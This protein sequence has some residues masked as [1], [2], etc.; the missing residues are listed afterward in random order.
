M[1]YSNVCSG[2]CTKLGVKRVSAS[3]SSLVQVSW[4]L[5]GKDESERDSLWELRIILQFG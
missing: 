5:G 4:V 2:A 1:L 3:L